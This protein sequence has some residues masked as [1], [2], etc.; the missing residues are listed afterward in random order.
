M[1]RDFVW[2][3]DIQDGV[4]RQVYVDSVHY[5]SAM[6]RIFADCIVEGLPNS[7]A[8]ILRGFVTGRG[9]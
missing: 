4:K 5:T 1:G 3:A 2:C 7:V 9:G 6:N 8:K